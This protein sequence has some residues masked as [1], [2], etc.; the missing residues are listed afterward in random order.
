MTRNF[1]I[2]GGMRNARSVLH[3]L[4]Y[5]GIV[6]MHV[7]VYTFLPAISEVIF[8]TVE[9]VPTGVAWSGKR[10]H[11]QIPAAFSIVGILK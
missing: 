4:F 2:S 9:R 1:L 7:G 8:R 10:L 3:G 11:T 5:A 6:E